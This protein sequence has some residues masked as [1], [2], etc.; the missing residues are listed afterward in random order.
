MENPSDLLP[1]IVVPNGEDGELM[2]ITESNVYTVQGDEI[3]E[4]GSD[5]RKA[6]K[7]LSA[8]HGAMVLDMAYKQDSGARNR[9]AVKKLVDQAT[10]EILLGGRVRLTYLL[11]SDG[12]K[13]VNLLAHR[14]LMQFIGK[15]GQAQAIGGRIISSAAAQLFLSA[16]RDRRY[17]LDETTMMLHLGVSKKEEVHAPKDQIGRDVVELSR[18][19]SKRLFK[20][21]L[22]VGDYEKK[23]E[24][25]A[26]ID[27]IPDQPPKPGDAVKSDHARYFS[28]Q[29]IVAAKWAKRLEIEN[30]EEFFMEIERV[31]HSRPITDMPQRLMDQIESLDETPG[32]KSTRSKFDEMFA[33]HKPR[34]QS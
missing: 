23:S 33:R 25:E 24:V 13:Y 10:A 16:D 27:A 22:L 4:M 31:L 5:F 3:V 17:I 32:T 2:H 28:A 26:W 7:K 11:N 12:G 21:V 9:E 1:I 19:I 14:N 18:V 6:L 30:E 20:E 29:E 8:A 15:N 34:K